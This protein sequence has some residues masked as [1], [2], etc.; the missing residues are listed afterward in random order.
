M[1]TGQS[2]S[3][4]PEC[5]GFSIA[6]DGP[7][8]V[9]WI[10]DGGVAQAAGV[11]LGDQLLEL[12]GHNVR[13]MSAEAVATLAQ[14]SRTMPPT[15]GVVARLQR[16]ELVATRRWGFGLTLRGVR[17]TQVDSVDP[18]GPAYQAGIRPGLLHISHRSL[19]HMLC[20]VMDMSLM[21]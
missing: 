2:G 10:D 7:S 17:P 12:D 5:Y 6:G 15:L 21:H 19:S 1:P 20:Y 3:V 14:H 9:I 18:P 13:D 8:Y 11:Y 4:W 16:V